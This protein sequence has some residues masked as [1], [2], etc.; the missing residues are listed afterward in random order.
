MSR[1]I[2]P[3][4]VITVLLSLGMASTALAKPTVAVLGIEVIDPSGKVDEKATAVA[5]QLTRELRRRA[6]M[7][8]GPFVLAPGPGKD[9]LELKLLSDCASEGRSCMAAIGRELKADRLMYGKLEKQSSGY[10]VSLNLLNVS[11]KSMER[12]TS[13]LIPLAETSGPGISSWGRKLYN[14]LTGVPDMGTI[15]VKTNLSKG[16]V[17]ID[18]EVK[19]SVNANGTLEISGVS[20]GTHQVSVE[21]DDRPTFERSVVVRAGQTATVSA[22]L[23]AAP[24]SGGPKRL[25]IAARPGGASRVL[26]WTSLVLT[27]VGATAMTVTGLQVRGSYKDDQIKAVEAYQAATGVQLDQ[28]NACNDAANRSGPE[29]QAVV[30]ACD[31]GK[32]RASL[33]NLFLGAS[34]VS[35]VA[36]GYFYYKGYIV[37][38]ASSRREIARRR[39]ASR[40]T[41]TVT[42][43]IGPNHI[44]AGIALEF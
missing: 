35:A 27:G 33:S 2:G 40:R 8:K 34:I 19:G 32:S 20:A 22:T 15:I 4:S 30:D 9:L 41:V 16:T 17:L 42:P 39:K 14:R 38:K 3:V 18:G 5:K 26:F 36:A 31:S 24:G 37:P 7:G 1:H 43:Q 21:S 13:D 44:G 25:G 6:S 28:G 10:Q 12:N 29:A 23:S 11:T